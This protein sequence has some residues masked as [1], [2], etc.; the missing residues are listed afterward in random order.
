MPSTLF[1]YT[2]THLS[3]RQPVRERMRGGKMRRPTETE[4]K[5]EGG[6]KEAFQEKSIKSSNNEHARF[7]AWYVVQGSS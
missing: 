4:G 6:E 5:E 1:A 2:Y 3:N 7:H